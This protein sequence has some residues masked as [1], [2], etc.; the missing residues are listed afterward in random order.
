[1]RLCYLHC[2]KEWT[3]RHRGGWPKA[4]DPEYPGA[5]VRASSVWSQKLHHSVW[6]PLDS[7][8]LSS[9]NTPPFQRSA[10]LHLFSLCFICSYLYWRTRSLLAGVQGPP[11]TLP[12]TGF[13][14]LS[15]HLTLLGPSFQWYNEK[16]V[17]IHLTRY[18]GASSLCLAFMVDTW[19]YKTTKSWNSPRNSLGN[20]Q[21]DSLSLIQGIWRPETW[22]TYLR[23]YTQ[24]GE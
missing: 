15:C 12:L 9:G 20:S 16:L 2:I 5:G 23:S 19:E 17:F 24:L 10:H 1:M 22:K 3:L 18:S 4:L 7:R 8:D 13:L 14:A 6:G 21:S 11:H